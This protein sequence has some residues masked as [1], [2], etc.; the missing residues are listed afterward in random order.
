M[1]SARQRIVAAHGGEPFRARA[2]VPGAGLQVREKV[3]SE[4][5]LTIFTRF[6]SLRRLLLGA[7]ASCSRQSP[8]EHQLEVGPSFCFDASG[9][10]R[11]LRV[12]TAIAIF[13][14][15]CRPVERERHVFEREWLPRQHA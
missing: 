10:T 5:L 6:L 4:P 14:R 11:R 15:V 12:S 1:I 7:D 2:A 9:G 13:G 3:V 8:Q